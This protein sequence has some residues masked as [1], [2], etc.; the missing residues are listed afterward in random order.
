VPGEVGGSEIYARSLVAAIRAAEPELELVVYAGPEA[1]RSLAE[2]P[3]ADGV[4]IVQSPVRSRS[5][6][7]RVAAELTWLPV[8]ARRDQVDV[9]HSLGTT[10]PPVLRNASVVT[11]L[12]LIYHHYPQTFPLASR[13]GLRLVVPV[14]VRR[15]ERVIAI[16]EAGR[17]DVLKTLRIDPAK[18]DVVY[19]GAGQDEGAEPTP[20]RELRE[21]FALVEG[22]LVLTV[23]A[24]LR[25]KNLD[26]LV[27]AFALLEP[28]DA[29]L[30]IV[31]HAGLEQDALR[32]YAAAAGVA[33]RVLFT[34]WIEERELE[35]FYAAAS[36][37]AYP[38]LIEGF[39]MPVLEAMRRGVPVACSNLSALPEVA[40]KA[41]ELFEPDDPAAIA[42]AIGRLLA[43]DS[44]RQELIALGRRRVREFTWERAAQGTLET[45]RRALRAR[46][47]SSTQRQ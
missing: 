44:R 32:A 33:R 45:Y 30:V 2:E 7:R 10:A 1:V 21:K 35:G 3:W 14:G 24:A 34:G 5:K 47:R 17:R 23:S 15:A 16:S 42:A 13:L 31:G 25:H 43:D 27:D 12:D 46:S 39:G 4:K 37:F 41:A 36:V 28:G 20:E 8:R 9:L 11:V 19:L 29:R 6:P 22:P 40:G 18:I 26:R 38:S